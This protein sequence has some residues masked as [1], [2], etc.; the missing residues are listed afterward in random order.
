M[1]SLLQIP[2]GFEIKRPSN[3]HCKDSQFR[4]VAQDIE[5]LC[6]AS[7]QKESSEDSTEDPTSSK[8]KE[9]VSSFSSNKSQ[10]SASNLLEDVLWQDNDPYQMGILGD[11]EARQD[12]YFPSPSAFKKQAPNEGCHSGLAW[13]REV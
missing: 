6:S 13:L 5:I 10:F 8:P 3:P 1:P 2:N 7:T 4:S 9:K 11:E 12:P